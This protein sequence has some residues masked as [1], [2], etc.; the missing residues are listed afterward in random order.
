MIPLDFTPGHRVIRPATGMGNTFLFKIFLQ[1]LRNIAGAIV[2][3]MGSR[4]PVHS[5][6]AKI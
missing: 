6:Q 1:C 3:T 5:C 4:M 2:R